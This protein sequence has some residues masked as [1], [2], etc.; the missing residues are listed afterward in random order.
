MS[1]TVVITTYNRP[2]LL[3]RAIESALKQ[4]M[5]ELE[6][7][8]VD[9]ASSPPVAPIVAAYP[10][11]L[12]LRQESNQGPGPARNRGIAHA[13]HP[14]VAILDDDDELLPG[15]LATIQERL[16]SYPDRHK[17]P[18]FQFSHGNG[19]LDEP[20]R[21]ICFE[22]YQTGAIR[23]D[24]LPVITRGLFLD[25]GYAYPNLRIGAEH[26]LWW[27]IAYRF[28]IPT[29]SERVCRLH[30]DAPVRL[31]SPAT[32]VSRAKEFAQMQELTLDKFG[33]FLKERFPASYRTRKLGAATYWMLAGDRAKARAHLSDADLKRSPV[34]VALHLLSWMPQ[35][36]VRSLFSIYR[37]MGQ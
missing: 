1:F 13:S 29:W 25:L 21:L 16:E 5:E 28:G 24:F 17:Y 12:Y 4:E 18:V 15:A 14:L 35:T 26:L 9:D 2:K 31:T 20:F 11:V 30:G 8:V 6:I 23:G 10:G 19:K 22:D 32:Q 3:Q 36:L 7:I 27:E 33:N 37:S 34:A